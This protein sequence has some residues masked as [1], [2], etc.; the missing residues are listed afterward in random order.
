[1]QF[2]LKPNFVKQIL[3]SERIPNKKSRSEEWH[4]FLRTALSL[5]PP[6]KPLRHKHTK[7]NYQEASVARVKAVSLTPFS[8]SKFFIIGICVEWLIAT[9]SL[10]PIFFLNFYPASVFLFQLEQ[11]ETPKFLF[12]IICKSISRDSPKKYWT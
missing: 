11:L 6:Q 1:M 12:L 8:D 4:Y 7:I 9:F 10:D 5:R 2:T 3:A